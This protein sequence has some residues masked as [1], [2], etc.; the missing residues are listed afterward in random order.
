MRLAKV[1]Y[2]GRAR[3]VLVEEQGYRLLETESLVS[4]LSLLASRRDLP[5]GSQIGLDSAEL[6]VPVEAEVKCF[7]IGLNYYSHMAEANLPEPKHP[8][9]FS[10]Y[11]SVLIGP[12]DDI[13]LPNTSKMVDWEA[14][15]GVVIGRSV[16]EAD[17]EQAA[18]AIGGFTILNDVSARD[19]QLHES[20]WIPGKNFEAS[21]PVG[22]WIVT[23]DELGP[24]PNLALSTRVDGEVLQDGRTTDQIF[25]PAQI[26]SYISEW[27][28]LEPG[29][30]IATGTC[31]GVGHCMTP[32]RYLGA[33]QVLETTIE[34]IGTLT[35][36][37]VSRRVLAS[38]PALA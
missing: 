20:Q 16:R 7:C 28:T 12:T 26:V 30:I 23:V 31:A 36:R 24:N 18:Q 29:D 17:P 37:C 1:K 13:L 4:A 25:T 38:A 19:Y 32:A 34:R 21:T 22:P 9:V 11:P 3:P 2:E 5:V 27:I 35:N 6:L 10:K 33:D 8:I 15:L 14:E